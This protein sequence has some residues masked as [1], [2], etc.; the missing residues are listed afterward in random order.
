MVP[1]AMNSTVTVSITVGVDINLVVQV[2]ME[3]NAVQYSA[4]SG[5]IQE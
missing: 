3:S 5:K 4:D 2:A 1:I